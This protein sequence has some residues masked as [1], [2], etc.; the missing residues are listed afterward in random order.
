MKMDSRMEMCFEIEAEEY[1]ERPTARKV[2]RPAQTIA[3]PKDEQK[4]RRAMQIKMMG[5]DA[6]LREY[7]RLLSADMIVEDIQREVYRR[8]L[9]KKDPTP[10]KEAVQAANLA[11]RARREGWEE[12]YE[13]GYIP[14]WAKK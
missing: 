8:G 6:L 11:A 1:A 3:A 12:E 10:S 2:N 4:A 14:G 9:V 13:D 7:H 5:N